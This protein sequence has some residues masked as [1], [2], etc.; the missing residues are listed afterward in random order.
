MPTPNPAPIFQLRI[1]LD[2]ISPLIWRR[3]L[4]TGA[5][6]IAELHTTIQIAFGWSVSHLHQFVIHGKHDGIAYLGGVRFADNPDHVRLA[7]FRFR[8]LQVVEQVQW[9][10]E[11]LDDEVRASRKIAK[12]VAEFHTYITAN[13]SFIPNYGDRYRY[14]E[15]ISTAFVESTVNQVISKRFVKKQQM[16]WTKRGAHMLLQVRAQVLNEDLRSTFERWYGAMTSTN[17]SADL[18]A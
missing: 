2:R 17:V 8:A 11:D 7:D 16:R 9:H 15:V 3:L 5:T 1:R 18:A 14:G 12:S 4:V 6:T 13:E 10:L